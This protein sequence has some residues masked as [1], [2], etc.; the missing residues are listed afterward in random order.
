MVLV[1]LLLDTILL[2]KCTQRVSGNDSLLGWRDVTSG[3]QEGFPWAT[4]P[5]L[6]LL[7]VLSAVTRAKSI[8]NK[9]YEAETALRNIKYHQ[10]GNSTLE[11][12]MHI[13][14]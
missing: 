1:K 6:G 13:S 3:V 7:D 2:A 10:D 11:R 12:T 14:S 4:G 9:E 8:K 5:R